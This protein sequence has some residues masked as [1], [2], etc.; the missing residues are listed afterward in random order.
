MNHCPNC[1]KYLDAATCI[2]SQGAAPEPD[3]ITICAYCGH[4]MAFDDTLRLRQLTST[5][6]YAVAGDPLILAAQRAR[7]KINE[8]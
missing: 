5:E 1:H 2:S 3:D 6:I 8:R 7:S 4:L